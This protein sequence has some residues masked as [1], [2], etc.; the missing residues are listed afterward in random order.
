MS[1]N[2]FC[3]LPKI[4]KSIYLNQN[5]LK[6]LPKH[7]YKLSN[8]KNTN[9]SHNLLHDI[10]KLIVKLYNLKYLNLN[11]NIIFNIHSSIGKLLKIE[12]ILLSN[13]NIKSVPSSIKNLNNLSFLDLS[14]NKLSK[15]PNPRK[16]LIKLKEL[17]LSNNLIT[18][19]ETIYLSGNNILRLPKKFLKCSTLQNLNLRSNKII[20]LHIDLFQSLKNLNS[21]NLE[22]NPIL[23]PVESDYIDI[24]KLKKEMS[25]KLI[26]DDILYEMI[27]KIYIKLT[28]K[29]NQFNFVNSRKCKSFILPLHIYSEQELLKK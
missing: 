16:K 24:F 29:S 8:L 27:K 20:K 14:H 1:C 10:P 21:L 13:N 15:F 17:F 5:K 12:K 18:N 3:K 19:F 22:E 2:N 6:I 25:D 9:L 26:L 7:F 4:L 23:Y 11:N 28:K